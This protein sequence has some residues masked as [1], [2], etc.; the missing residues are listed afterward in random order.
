MEAK[1]ATSES[2]CE[3]E[4]LETRFHAFIEW[5]LRAPLCPPSYDPT[6]TSNVDLF[7][8]V[9]MRNRKPTAMLEYDLYID[10]ST[11][12]LIWMHISKYLLHTGLRN[13]CNY[14]TTF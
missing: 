7:D 9:K 2:V 11:M 13:P 4:K 12:R 8:P 1:L 5:T 6:A 10:V 14:T 3:H